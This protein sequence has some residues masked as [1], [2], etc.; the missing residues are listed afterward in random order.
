MKQ[1]VIIIGN[2]FTTRLGIIWSVAQVGC[3][4]VIIDIGYFNSSNPP[5]PIDGYSKYVNQVIFFE[6]K[7]GRKGLVKLLLEKFVDPLN[8]AIII[9]TSD[10]SAVSIDNDAIK[11][12]FLVPC[13]NNEI[14]SFEYWM[15]KVNQKDVALKVGL[16]V[17]DSVIIER[18]EGDFSIPSSIK[19]PCFTKPLASIGGGK[20]C[21]KRCDNVKDLQAVLKVAKKNDIKKILAE[22]F[23]NIER[24]YAVL[25]FS[26]GEKVVIPGVIQFV[27]G[28]ESHQGIAMLGIVKPIKGFEELLEKFSAFVRQIGFYGLFD[29]DFFESDGRFYFGEMN[30]R[31]GGSATAISKMDVN[32][33]AMFV[34]S[35]LGERIDDMQ[36]NVTNSATYVNER[37]CMDD[38]IAG[39]IS[40]LDFKKIISS[41]DIH[42]II[43]KGDREPEKQFYKEIWKILFNYKRIVK[44]TRHLI[45]H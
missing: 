7:Y 22:D 27:R 28:S 14:C 4:I 12:H 23:L 11:E 32:L 38:W 1:K 44:R 30:L 21:L 2:S 18:K 39:K 8:K 13:I 31:I 17:A 45:S 37:M 42:F 24:E 40:S 36:Q 3:E 20:K 35:M 33:P 29:I 16:D 9:P 15:D 25:G 19:Y 43:N 34:K 5:M 10:F 41:A 26:D 6:R